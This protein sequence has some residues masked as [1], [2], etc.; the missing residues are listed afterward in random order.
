MPS[1]LASNDK[2]ARD[3]RGA[4]ARP[5]ARDLGVLDFGNPVFNFG[6]PV[7]GTPV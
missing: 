3:R 5:D 7:F 6:T 4:A 1:T 2:A